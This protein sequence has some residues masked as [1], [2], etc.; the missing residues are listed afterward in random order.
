MESPK[1]EN[2]KKAVQWGSYL[3]LGLE[4]AVTLLLFIFAGRYLDGKFGTNPWL[5]IAGAAV[6]FVAGFYLMFR[7]IANLGQPKDKQRE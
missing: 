1:G 2:I 7:S 3:G 4:F 5:L 6:G